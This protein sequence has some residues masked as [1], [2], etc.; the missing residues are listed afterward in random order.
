MAM[1]PVT[2]NVA[3]SP[4]NVMQALG[5]SLSSLGYTVSPGSDGWSGRAEVGSSTNR[6]LAGG[7]ARRMIIDYTMTSAENSVQLHL[8]PGMTGWSGGLM[9]MSRAKK[10]YAQA[11]QAVHQALQNQQLLQP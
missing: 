4:A 9:G 1:D 11:C 2:W 3:N 5:V 10:D 8:R 6:I 7:F